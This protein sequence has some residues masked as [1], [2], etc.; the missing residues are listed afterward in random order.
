VQKPIGFVKGKNVGMQ[1]S[2]LTH[3]AQQLLLLQH[4]L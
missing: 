3:A 4:V 2:L 1:P